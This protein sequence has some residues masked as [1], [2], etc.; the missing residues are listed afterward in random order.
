MT[1][2]DDMVVSSNCFQNNSTEWF[3]F[4]GPWLL[5]LTLVISSVFTLR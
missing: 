2:P 5:A 1:R 3:V 4:S